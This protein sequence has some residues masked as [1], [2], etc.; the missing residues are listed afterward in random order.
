MKNNKKSKLTNKNIL[1]KL[2]PKLLVLALGLVFLLAL[3][4]CGNGQTNG[5]DEISATGLDMIS[6]MLEVEIPYANNIYP[7]SQ[8]P[9][10]PQHED[11][12]IDK[13]NQL[14]QVKLGESL[15]SAFLLET[16]I[17]Y[18]DTAW[19]SFVEAHV[20]LER[21]AGDHDWLAVL[22]V[23]YDLR[24]DKSVEAI[25]FEAAYDLLDIDVAVKFDNRPEYVGIGSKYFFLN[26]DYE[27][28]YHYDLEP[29]F[30]DGDYWLSYSFDGMTA[31]LYHNE[32]EFH[33]RINRLEITRPDCQTYRGIRLGSTREEVYSAYPG[34]TDANYW[35]LVG[36]YLW[37][38]KGLD[39]YSGG[40][41]PVLLFWFTDEKVSK[42]DLFN[43]FY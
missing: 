16:S 17:F 39:N 28:E 15:A 24:S 18:E 31:L 7:A 27:K 9:S 25:V 13:L 35:D 30:N 21:T 10:E 37:Y 6:Q 20:V 38:D 26:E 1:R 14:G 42:I 11:V 29:V 32:F 36:D 41:D 23:S 33:N 34:I 2:D 12:R 40:F 5:E 3:A 4:A 8:E 22:G 19:E 43:I